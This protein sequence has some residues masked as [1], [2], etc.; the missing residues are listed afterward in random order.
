MNVQFTKTE[1]LPATD[2]KLTGDRFENFALDKNGEDFLLKV[3]NIGKKVD[4]DY[5]IILAIMYFESKMDP[6]AQNSST[7]ATGL[8]QFMPFTAKGMGTSISELKNMSAIEQ[9]DYVEKFFM[10]KKRSGLTSKVKSPEEAYLL[11][12]YPIAVGKSDDFILGSEVSD[13]R[14]KMIYSQ[15]KPFDT[16]KD[17][18]ISKG[19]V[20]QYIKKKWGI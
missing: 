7:N 20:L 15:N 3:Q 6:S 14:A 16:N 10:D 18:F 17:G 9:L 1:S 12:F 5:K 19:E 11:V 2:I 8:I 4:L 13:E